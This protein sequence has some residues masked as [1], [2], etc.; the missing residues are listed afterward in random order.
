LRRALRE[1]V[2]VGARDVVI[3]REDCEV[4]IDS[5]A[6]PLRDASGEVVAAI[7]VFGDSTGRRAAERQLEAALEERRQAHRDLSDFA[8]HVAHDLA[9]PARGIA[10][11]AELLQG[12]ESERF[13]EESR[14]WLELIVE[15]TA[16]MRSLIDELLLYAQAGSRPFARRVVD[17]TRVVAATRDQLRP[18]LVET[19]GAL[20][21][22][23]LPNVVGDPIQ[24]ARVI[25]NLVDNGLKFSRPGVAPEVVVDAVRLGELWQIRVADNGVGVSAEDREQIFAPFAR[26]ANSGAQG[27]GLGLAICRRIVERH[28]GSIWAETVRGP[29]MRI[30]FTLPAAETGASTRTGDASPPQR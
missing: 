21:A 29:G 16:Q 30:C 2:S 24:I 26:P 25:Q 4:P 14:R 12:R 11:F 27:S 3:R 20:I 28:G 18:R 22:R 9:A 10:G 1:G 8:S 13:D 17:L 19:K 5:F 6:T 23:A 7:T 15:E